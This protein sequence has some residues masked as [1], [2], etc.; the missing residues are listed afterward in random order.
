M[1]L[2]FLNNRYIFLFLS[3]VPLNVDEHENVVTKLCHGITDLTPPEV[4]PFVHQLLLLTKSQHSMILFFTL[5]EYYFKH[6]YSLEES[7]NVVDSTNL[8]ALDAIG[9]YFVNY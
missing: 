1:Y 7:L 4:P 2:F 3:Y 6:I 8:E 9:N 5:K